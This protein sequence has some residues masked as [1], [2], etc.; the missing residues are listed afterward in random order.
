MT[1]TKTIHIDLDVYKALEANRY[2]IQED[3]NTI[4]RRLLSLTPSLEQPQER[5]RPSRSS[6]PYS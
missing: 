5:L 1:F 4:L 6:R 3:Y 2:S